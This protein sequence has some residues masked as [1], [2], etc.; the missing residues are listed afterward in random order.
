MPRRIGAQLVGLLLA[1]FMPM[2]LYLS[3]YTT[4][5]TLA[6]TLATAT[7]Y[8][9]LR[10][11][12]TGIGSTAR[13]ALLG[14]CLGAA[15][16]TKV[17]DVLL[18]PFVI[19]ALAHALAKQRAHWKICLR[20][21]GVMVAVCCIVCGWFY[22]RVWIR[23]GAPLV[24]AWDVASGFAWWQDP[25]YH[26][27][28]DYTRFGRSLA[29][30]LFSGFDGF[31]DGVYSTLWGDG[32]CGGSGDLAL[33]PPWNYHLVVAGFVLASVPMAMLLCGAVAATGRFLARPSGDQFVPLAFFG[34]VAFGLVFMS[35]KVPVYGQVK[36]FYG[37][38]SL[39]T[40][41][42]FGAIGWEVLTRGRKS[43]QIAF[44]TAL[45][46]WGMNSF[47]SM[48]IRNENASVHMLQ[49]IGFVGQNKSEAALSEFEAA[50]EAEPANAQARYLLA[51]K[52]RETG[53]TKEALDQASRAVELN[54]MNAKAH[55][56]LGIILASQNQ[57]EPAIAQG[58]IA[59]RVGPECLLAHQS[60]TTWLA[61]SRRNDEGIE[62]AREG[63]AI[64]P[65]DPVLHFVLGMIQEDKG[66]RAAAIT[67]LTY[68]VL[69]RSGWAEAHLDLGITLVQA[70]EV[71]RG[72]AELEQAV[73]LAP[74]DA[75][76][77]NQAAWL[78]ATFPD[79][80]ARNGLEAVRL[81][82]HA[83]AL[84]GNRDPNLL[85]TLAAAYAEMGSYPDAIHS[86]QQALALAQSAGDARLTDFCGEMLRLF[87]SN[88]PYR[89][90]SVPAR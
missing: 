43:L 70:G 19:L 31:W 51:Q 47:A 48:W 54:P 26:T 7:I 60:L 13:Y 40:L 30:P 88:R 42:L 17:T 23:F 83:V 59:I 89:Q 38:G 53:R 73:R 34:A 45:L 72:L 52:L 15:I 56:Q 77:L 11:L 80:G 33:R 76:L 71:G 65:C 67:Q 75:A 44:G 32:L 50:V 69:L 39:L 82:E 84:S 6:A 37:L 36:A 68:A 66:D 55:V 27:V 28:G 10:L 22:I 14:L 3:H 74:D 85:K 18:A 20:T 57:M 24:G 21:V 35:L 46:I 29:H 41:C 8:L 79:A 5:E 9:T 25:A 12:A 62:A 78:M 87:E 63:L 64:S 61:M 1:A 4:N 86:A 90:P 2:Q 16:L 58:R 81:A 49:G